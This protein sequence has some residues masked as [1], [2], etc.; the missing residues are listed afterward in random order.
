MHYILSTSTEDS[1]CPSQG[2]NAA[3]TEIDLTATHLV[4][5]CIIGCL[6]YGF[7]RFSNGR[8]RQRTLAT[9]HACARH[10]QVL[11]IFLLYKSFWMF[12]EK[13]SRPV[14]QINL[15]ST[16]D[17]W[18]CEYMGL[19]FFV[20][21]K[22]CPPRRCICLCS[23]VFPLILTVLRRFS[24]NPFVGFYKNTSGSLSGLGFVD[25]WAHFSRMR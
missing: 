19:F 7:K 14:R 11:L 10:A 17:V 23:L 9:S 12:F 25:I 6:E 8:F 22:I 20:C 16:V 3:Q 2:P 13:P 4:W 15:R 18:F 1:T 5:G 24:Q 21:D